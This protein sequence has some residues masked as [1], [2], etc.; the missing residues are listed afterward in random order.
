MN[1]TVWHSSLLQSRTR[2]QSHPKKKEDWFGPYTRAI[3]LIYHPD[4]YS[5]TS[6]KLANVQP[7][8]IGQGYV[9]QGKGL[10][11][12]TTVEFLLCT[13][14]NPDGPQLLRRQTKVSSWTMLESYLAQRT[15]HSTWTGSVVTIYIG[16]WII[17]TVTLKQ[18]TDG[19]WLSG[20]RSMHI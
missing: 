12:V 18:D 3:S 20:S 11:G 16:I 7:I 1:G 6:R 2:K 15:H 5:L 10:R 19:D 14:T 9:V 8:F 13:T 17:D 4:V